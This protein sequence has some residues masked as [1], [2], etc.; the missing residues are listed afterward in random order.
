MSSNTSTTV[1]GVPDVSIRS[2]PS[3]DFSIR[4]LFEDAYPAQHASRH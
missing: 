2:L 3:R 1:G 4:I